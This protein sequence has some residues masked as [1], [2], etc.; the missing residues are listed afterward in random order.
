[1]RRLVILMLLT[2]LVGHGPAAAM[3]GDAERAGEPVDVILLLA[4]DNSASVTSKTLDMQLSGHAFAFR[5][6]GVQAALRSGP[7]GSIAVGVMLWSDPTDARL[8][9]P[10]RRVRTPE[11]AWALARDIEA[12]PRQQWSGSTGLGAALA[13]S[14]RYINK[15]PFQAPR[16]VVDISSNGFSNIG[17]QPEP[18]R[19]LLRADGIEVNA[20]VILDEYDWLERYFLQSVVTG[21]APFV[22]AAGEPEDYADALLRKLIRE[23]SFLDVPVQEAR[24]WHPSNAMN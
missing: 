16:R 21:K 19:D 8:V 13:W 11:D 22:F 12:Q 10:W 6:P 15:A 14:Q 7:I 24:S 20:L 3:A 17:P 9:I 1:M 4:I 18:A 23:V 2:V 5:D